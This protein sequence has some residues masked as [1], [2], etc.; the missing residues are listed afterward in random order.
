MEKHSENN[1]TSI[2][3]LETSSCEHPHALFLCGAS[4]RCQRRRSGPIERHALRHH[5]HRHRIRVACECRGR[6]RVPHAGRHGRIALALGPARQS[7]IWAAAIAR[8]SRWKAALTCAPA[9]SARAAACSGG[10]RSSASRVPYGTVAFGRQYTMTYLALMGA[11]MIGP[12][13]YGL[14][15][16]DAYVPNARADNSVTYIGAYAGR[17]AGRE[18]FVRTRCGRYRQLAGTGNVHGIG[19]GARHANAA[20]GR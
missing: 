13:I 9:I 20:T 6:Q 3:G 8:S 12:D 2:N 1:N 17:D 14:G 15:S 16:L 5:R 18:L 11:D 19:A 7:K 4:V 10:R